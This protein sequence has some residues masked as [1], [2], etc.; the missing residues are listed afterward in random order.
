MLGQRRL[1]TD[2]FIHSV[3]NSESDSCV[4]GAALDP[5]DTVVSQPCWDPIFVVTCHIL[6]EIRYP[7]RPLYPVVA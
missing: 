7:S 2:T 5:G 1:V 6:E 4:L 3:L